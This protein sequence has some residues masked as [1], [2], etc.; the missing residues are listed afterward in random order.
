MSDTG[1]RKATYR[2]Q[3]D[4][5]GERVRYTDIAPVS[6]NERCRDCGRKHGTVVRCLADGRWFDADDQTWRDR[7]GRRSAWPNVVEYAEVRDLPVTV[8]LVRLSGDN[9]GKLRKLCRRCQMSQESMRNAIR[10]R[11]R[12]LSRRALGDLFLGVYSEPDTEERFKSLS[13]PKRAAKKPD[14]PS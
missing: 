3:L 12:A 7:R 8:R 13:K 4:P 10:N 6:L 5:S 9:G 14:A 11:I 2:P 1:R